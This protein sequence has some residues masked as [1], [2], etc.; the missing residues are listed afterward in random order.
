MTRPLRAG[1]R[2]LAGLVVAMAL[3]YLVVTCATI[4]FRNANGDVGSPALPIFVLGL[5]P[6]LTAIFLALR[7]WS[8]KPGKS[9]TM[10]AAGLLVLLAGL[11]LWRLLT[12]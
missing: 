7:G 6:S 1:N 2:Y 5:A 9:E 10:S 3:A 12:T 4:L 8:A 11:A